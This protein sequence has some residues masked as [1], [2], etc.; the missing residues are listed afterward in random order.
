MTVGD[1]RLSAVSNPRKELPLVPGVPVAGP[2]CWEESAV[3][4]QGP[5]RRTACPW[6]KIKPDNKRS[7][8]GS[9]SSEGN[10]APDWSYT[11]SPAGTCD[12]TCSCQRMDERVWAI[13]LPAAT[14]KGIMSMK[15]APPPLSILNTQHRPTDEKSRNCSSFPRPF[16][17]IYSQPFPVLFISSSTWQNH[18]FGSPYVFFLYI[19]ILM[20]FSESLFY[21]LR[22]TRLNHHKCFS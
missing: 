1:W 12:R 4:F 13:L 16:F 7:W 22:L 21:P 11:P 15:A 9:V 8:Y 10:C 18:F 6:R 3:S 20:S 19:L 17:L 5:M 14:R 2:C